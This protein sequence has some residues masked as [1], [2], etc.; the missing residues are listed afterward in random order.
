MT[1]TARLIVITAT[2]ILL[3]GCPITPPPTAVQTSSRSTTPPAKIPLQP[4]ELNQE[5][6]KV[7]LDLAGVREEINRLRN[8]IEEIQFET[9]NAKRRQQ[10]LFQKLEDRLVSVERN[11]QVLSPQST[12]AVQR[13]NQQPDHPDSS[14]TIGGDTTSVAANVPL[15]QVPTP[16]QNNQDTTAINTSTPPA[17]TAP[18]LPPTTLAEQQAYD[19]AFELLTQSLYAD[20][21]IQFRQMITTWPHSPLAADAYYWMSET[22]YVNRQFEHAL[23]GFKALISKYPDS[24]RVPE[25]LLKIG[26]IQHDIGDYEKA[27]Q[28]FRDILARFHGHKVA[29]SAQTRLRRI[30]QTIQ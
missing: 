7:L 3:S 9:E 28:T 8:A 25:A 13:N 24:P 26:Y 16:S 1:I 22:M 17:A 6:V 4:E 18:K 27:V 21:I 10:D 12:A 23:S 11:R 29:I 5:V 20:A 14:E 15:N 2:I 30:E 19:Q